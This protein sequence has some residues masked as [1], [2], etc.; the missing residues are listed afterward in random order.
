[1]A[2]FDV[3]RWSRLSPLFD[4]LLDADEAG[5]ASLLAELRETEPEVAADLAALLDRHRALLGAAFLDG[6]AV[7]GDGAGQVPGQIVGNYT[8]ERLLGHGGMGSVWLARRS[9]GRYQGVAAIKFMHAAVVARGGQ[10]RF[11]REGSL[12]AKLAHPHIVRLMDAGVSSTGQPYLAMEYVEGEAIDDYCDARSLPVVARLRLFLDVLGA[13]SYAHT[14]LVLHRDLKPSNILVTAAGEV[15][16]LDFGIARLLEDERARPEPGRATT[17]FVRAFTPEY[18]APEQVR[19]EDVTTGTDVYSLGILLYVLLAGAHPYVRAGQTTFERQQAALTVDPVRL[20]DAARLAA[21]EVAARRGATPSRIARRLRGDLDNIVAKALKKSPGERY[22]T[23]AAFADDVRRHLAHEPVTARP[24]SVGYR[25]RMFVRRH[26]WGVAAAVLLAAGVS[27]GV[28]AVNRERAV[29]E[30]R[31]NQVR[32]LANKLFDIDVAVRQLPGATATR[33]IIVNTA[34]EYLEGLSGEV[35]GDPGLALEIGTAYM[36]VGR[37]QGVP[38][39]ANLGQSDLADRSLATAERLIGSA[40][41]AEPGNR[42][43]MLRAAQIAHDRMILAGDRRP[44][45]Q[46]LPYARQS[47]EW[48]DRWAASTAPLPA[49]LEIEQALIAYNNVANRFR[50][51]R[52]YDTALRL[53]QQGVTLAR[54]VGTANADRQRASL[55]ITLT[56]IHRDRGDLDEALR[57]IREGQAVMEASGPEV[58]TN[59][60]PR[61][62]FVL[63]LTTE[64]EVLGQP[65]GP[66]LGRPAD[67]VAPLTRG[68]ALVDE[69]V[70]RDGS[71]AQ[72]RGSLAAIGRVLAACVAGTDPAR[73]LA[74]HDH[75]LAHLAEVKDNPRSR[76]DEARALADSSRMLRRLGRTGEVR[77]RLDA[78]FARLTALK[79][80]PSDR[81]DPA[82]E[83][84]HALSARADAEADAQRTSTAIATYEELLAG[85]LAAEPEVDADLTDAAAVTRL[86]NALARLHSDAGDD[87]RAAEY[88]QRARA[89]WQ[90]WER[91]LPGNAFV[92]RQ[93]EATGAHR[94]M[95]TRPRGENQ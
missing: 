82:S 42:M 49:W 65:D 20:S 35:S 29:A 5:R 54:S 50:I 10:E 57:T 66:S 6:S 59:V 36:R 71:N 48:L 79:L 17:E 86:Y 90:G 40:L 23:V 9:D 3:G 55:H 76:R 26:R 84:D 91:T 69:L 27:I 85:V 33:Q 77:D 1:M 38:I 95:G 80:Y 41:R 15:K 24:D 39:S 32:Q 4:A 89:V 21:P 11:A 74:I 46:A 16:L 94:V 87:T 63:M 14:N 61:T 12:L 47:S 2:D 58:L 13:V 83:V 8:L 34:L 56:R 31:F 52:D 67:A 68:F 64:G 60:G 81:I 19:A 88:R 72:A 28:A 70:H 7:D 25:A 78:A 93:L 30:R 44:A 45:D 18:A 73:A 75:V 62:V 22:P 37:V 92:Q 43:A 53:I 51:A